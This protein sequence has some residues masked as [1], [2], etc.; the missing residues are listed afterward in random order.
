V[1]V[2]VLCVNEGVTVYVFDYVR[3]C[4]CMCV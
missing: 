2:N 4:E 1:C 3:V